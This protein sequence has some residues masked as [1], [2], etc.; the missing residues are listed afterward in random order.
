MSLFHKITISHIIRQSNDQLVIRP[1]WNYCTFEHQRHARCQIICHLF[2]TIND[3]P[4]ILWYRFLFRLKKSICPL[5]T[6]WYFFR[7]TACNTGTWRLWSHHN[8]IGH[9]LF[10]NGQPIQD[11]IQISF[12]GRMAELDQCHLYQHTLLCWIAHLTWKIWENPDI[13]H[14]HRR[15]YS[16]CLL[17]HHFK[18][19]CRCLHQICQIS[20]T[21]YHQ[22][23]P[24]VPRKIHH[25]LCQIT[26][27]HDNLIYKM[28]H[29]GNILTAD[30]FQQATENRCIHCSKHIQYI[31]ILQ[32]LPNI[33]GITL[34]QKTQG[35]T[36]GTVR[37]SGHVSQC[38]IFCI[39][40][41]SIC[42]F[43]QPL[44]NST[45]GNTSEIIPLT[46]GKDRNRNLVCLRGRQNKNNIWRRFLQGL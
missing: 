46:P 16:W 36:H 26:A 18:P 29:T 9:L 24:Q 1:F 23:I 21:L 13:P 45:R 22:K 14:Q 19:L 11:R 8:T 38:C 44:C 40:T 27:L 12:H 39:N 35:I 41:L 31:L 2:P 33:K 32:P 25:K 42:Q 28:D 30:T 10:K 34:I 20:G 37:H 17:P 43:S 4:Q 5:L 7:I 15:I 3:H 6:A